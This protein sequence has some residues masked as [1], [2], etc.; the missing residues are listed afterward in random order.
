MAQ[1]IVFFSGKSDDEPFF[2]EEM[3][4]FTFYSGFAI[5]QKQKSIRSLH[6]NVLKEHPKKK[7]LEISTKSE[8]PLGVRLSAFN[9]RFYD[10][11]SGESYPLEN[12]FQSAK[13][14]EYGGPY[15]D[16]LYVSP[17]EAK[18]DERH[19]TSGVLKCF[20]LNDWECPLEPK[21]MFYDW[22]YCKALS[23]DTTL[24]DALVSAGFDAFTD[25]EFN[26]KKSLNCQARAASIF[27]SLCERGV[28]QDY[29]DNKEEWAT[30]YQTDE[31]DKESE[32]IQFDFALR[33]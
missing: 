21:T 18:T 29:L 12:I 6:E 30:I 2:Y 8:I 9:L 5:S 26:Q 7:I 4:D 22:I 19:H 31:A 10:E 3:V 16:L 23:Q 20:R 32:Q 33:I 17:K 24:T 11:R 1:R 28:L 13:T 27:V 25:I 15:T 14:Y